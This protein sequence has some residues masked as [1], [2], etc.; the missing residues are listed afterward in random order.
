MAKYTTLSEI[1]HILKRPEVVIGSIVP[2]NTS[3]Y[4]ADIDN[5][6]TETNIV[7]SE[8]LIRIYVEVLAN[9]IDNI[10][11]DDSQTYIKISID[12]DYVTISNDGAIIRINKDDND[13]GL[14][15]HELIFGKLRTS[16][17][18]D[19][20][21]CRITSGKN[22]LGVKCTNILSSWFRVIGVD[23]AAHLKFVQIWTNNMKD[24][25]G[26]QITTPK[27][28]V[29]ITSVTFQPD[30][31]IFGNALTAPVIG[32]F[33]KIAIDAALVARNIKV[34]FNNKIIRIPT[35]AA[36]AH[37]FEP[38]SAHSISYA[39]TGSE[40][41]ITFA[42]QPHVS[43]VNGLFTKDGGQHLDAW[44]HCIF[45]KLVAEINKKIKPLTITAR[46][47][48]HFRLFVTATCDKPQFES[49]NKHKLVLPVL[50]YQIDDAV[51]KKILRWEGTV[52][53]IKDLV[54]AKQLKK[55]QT[56]LKALNKRTL[57]VSSKDYDPA[58]LAGTKSASKCILILCEGLSAKTFAVAGISKGMTIGTTTTK[59]RDYIGIMPLRGKFLNVRNVTN[60]RIAQ[61]AIITD[62]IHI[63]GL[64]FDRDYGTTDAGLN[65]GR[66][67]IIPD[68]DEDGIHIEGL[69]LNFFHCYFPSLF[70][71]P[72]PFLLSMKIP[73]IETHSHLYY[74][75]ET[76]NAIANPGP[77]KY[78]KGLGTI[79]NA[80]VPSRF[81]Q[82][83][84]I[85]AKDDACDATMNK[86]FKDELSDVRKQWMKDYNPAMRSFNLDTPA[87]EV[88]LP[89]TTFID[90]ELIKYAIENCKRSLPHLMDGLKESQRKVI[91]VAKT[92][93][94]TIKV[95]QLGASVAKETDYKH[96]EQNLFDTIIRMAQDFVGANNIPLLA[97]EGQFGS[98]TSGGKD[99][100]SPRYIFTKPMPILQYIFRAE[101]DP[102]LLQTDAEPQFY[103]PVIPMLLVNGSV[104]IGTGFSCNIPMY[105][106]RS[107]IAFIRAW[108]ADHTTAFDLQPWY[109][110]F[111][112]TICKNND[113]KYST[114]GVIHPTHDAFEVTEIPIGM[115]YD[116]FKE[117]CEQA[118]E[119][120]LITDWKFGK[121]D[122]NASS[123]FVYAEKGDDL[124]STLK[125]RS[126]LNLT[127]ITFFGYRN[128]I[129][130]I[131][132]ETIGDAVQEFCRIRLVFYEKRRQHLI[133]AL[134]HKLLLLQNKQRFI[135]DVN[136][137]EIIVFRTP[138]AAIERQLAEKNYYKDTTYDY[139][140]NMSISMFTAERYAKCEQL[141]AD[142]S[143]KLEM[144]T[145]C[146]DVDIWLAD[147]AELETILCN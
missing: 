139:L 136:S 67:C 99:A 96:G 79:K 110:K 121:S 137:G 135:G 66:V 73:V 52:Q 72:T 26:P 134:Q 78:F 109:N 30:A 53:M 18:Y 84:I 80:D 68:P 58:N 16:S 8:A 71:R 130:T 55:E 31:K 117:I 45:E 39:T 74:S 103:L 75:M 63:L 14:Y 64:K 116:Q 90:E 19:D 122:P 98:R 88:A 140:I 141:I 95:A 11:R 48:Q 108:L 83:F 38:T 86:A 92:V 124:M 41:C 97:A 44:K 77:H 85:F 47:I 56:A 10:S 23:P 105:N 118:K 133:S 21:Q 32:V 82:K 43:F 33:R 144:Y 22:G 5:N 93:T 113:K 65:Y 15:N 112:G 129:N 138:K 76:F 123:F 54:A 104:G 57:K 9:A 40:V 61:N 69:V 146:T 1:D 60:E 24:T 127:N 13:A 81:G 36:Y 102:I 147:L 142:T 59:G 7:V 62:L 145:S 6:I 94:S 100:A 132:Q 101:D 125:L 50:R 89:V 91:F 35:L 42:T 114:Y 119:K 25:A 70:N 87:K 131:C 34:Y 17:N 128:G 46:D 4:S 106:P 49:Q 115:C 28:P 51:I 37:A 126:Y 2:T 143:T 3:I 29:P 20:S 120:K 12:R 111:T 27:S 107:I